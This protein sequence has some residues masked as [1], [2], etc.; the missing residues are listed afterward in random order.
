VPRVFPSASPVEYGCRWPHRLQLEAFAAALLRGEPVRTSPEDAVENMGVIDAVYRDAGHP[1]R[2]PSCSATP[3]RPN[4]DFQLA[5]PLTQQFENR[6][7]WLML[8][9]SASPCPERLDLR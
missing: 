8:C 9:T 4:D 3:G 5:K 7:Y 2:E 1:I 6:R